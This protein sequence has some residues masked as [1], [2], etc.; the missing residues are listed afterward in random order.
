MISPDPTSRSVW[1]AHRS[2]RVWRARAEGPEPFR[3]CPWQCLYFL[4]EPQGQGSLR[5]LGPQVPGRSGS[6]RRSRSPRRRRPAP[7]IA[8]IAGSASAGRCGAASGG[9]RPPGRG[10]ARPVGDHRLLLLGGH[11]LDMR[12][13]AG[14]LG[15]QPVQQAL[16]QLEALGLVFVQRVALGVA[17]EADDAAQMVERHQMLAP[18]LVDGLQQHL[19]LDGAHGLGAVARGLCRHLLIGRAVSRSRITSSSTPSSS[20]QAAMGRSRPKVWRTF[21]ASPSTS[22]W[23]A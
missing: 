21:S 17:A 13:H 18:V 15:A 5:P 1:C 4:P 10:P 11:H 2:D 3:P 19:L 7:A 16:E 23:S 12:E 8:A 14:D 20:A 6:T 9:L 22:H